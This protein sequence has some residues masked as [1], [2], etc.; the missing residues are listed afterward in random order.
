MFLRVRGNAVLCGR[1]FLEESP[2]LRPIVEEMNRSPLVPLFMDHQAFMAHGEICPSAV[3]PAVASN[4]AGRRTVYPMKWGFTGKNGLLINA[5]VETAAE[6]PTFRDS[7]LAHRCAIPAS[8]YYE[9]EHIAGEN[10]KKK[11]GSKYAIR[12]ANANVIWLCGLYRMEK[13]APAFVILTREPCENLRFIHDRMPLI[14][15][16]E[17]VDKWIRPDTSPESLLPLA[18]Q[19]MIFERVI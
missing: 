9:W 18:E 3:V 14:L 12:A 7:W 1:Y 10:G 6:K 11:L 5:R 4:K 15:P 17:A 2:E 8:C 13:G 19:E 16:M